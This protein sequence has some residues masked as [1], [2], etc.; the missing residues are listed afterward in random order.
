MAVARPPLVDEPDLIARHAL[1]TVIE[2]PVL[3]ALRNTDTAGREETCPPILGAPPPAEFLPFPLSQQRFRGD[4]RPTKVVVFAGQDNVGGIDILAR[5][6]TH[7]PLRTT[8]TQSL[9]E[10]CAGTVPRIGKRTAETRTGGDDAVDLLDHNLRL[11][12]AGLP[13]L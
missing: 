6:Q 7:R 11:V 5:R 8:L 13:I 3:M 1:H 9:T 12:R 2:H 10:R 4:R